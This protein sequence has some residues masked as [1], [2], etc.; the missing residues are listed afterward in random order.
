[1]A[2]LGIQYCYNSCIKYLSSRQ[3][4]EVD[5][6]TLF[7]FEYVLNDK[8]IHLL[9]KQ[10]VLTPEE[11]RRIFD[12]LNRCL[13]NEPLSYILGEA[14]FRSNRYD[15]GPG[16]L[17]PRPETEELV[18][19]TALI[20]DCIYKQNNDLFIYECG[21]GTG[22]I[23]I[24]LAQ[25]FSD[26]SFTGWDI[27]KSAIQTTLKNMATYKVKNL[28]V[29]KG[30]FFDGYDEYGNEGA[31]QVVVSNPPYISE[32]AYD[33]LDEHVKCE[34]KEALVAEN[35]GLSV[36]IAL[37][38]MASKYRFILAC[39]IGYDQREKLT[40]CFHDLDLI[41]KSDLSG[42]DRFLF[43]FPPRILEKY[44]GLLSTLSN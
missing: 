27:S 37:V 26:I 41:F 33:L 9:A 40:S 35:D 13:N 20:I 25:M 21:L 43:Y 38:E 18:G 14:Y 2:N 1:M 42:K 19:Y 31:V 30:S 3:F 29:Y 7:V 36:I 39:E 17:I 24:E 34:P 11:Y 12:I 5:I 16:V 23:S 15:V 10:Y 8:Y 22:V 6:T 4:D 32:K 44:S 28:Q